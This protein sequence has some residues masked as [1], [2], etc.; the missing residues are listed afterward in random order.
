MITLDSNIGSVTVG[1]AHWPL[2]LLGC[3]LH[4]AAGMSQELSQSSVGVR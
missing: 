2:A 4:S 1:G 3:K